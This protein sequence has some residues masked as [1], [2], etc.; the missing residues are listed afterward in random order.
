M[1][2]SILSTRDVV[3]MD[4][5]TNSFVYFYPDLR[6][7]ESVPLPVDMREHRLELPLFESDSPDVLY[8]P[9]PPALFD[10]ISKSFHFIPL[11]VQDLNETLN[12]SA[13]LHL[14]DTM[15]SSKP[16]HVSS[17]RPL[18]ISDAPNL[19]SQRVN[20]ALLSTQEELLL[21]LSNDFA[22]SNYHLSIHTKS[23]GGFQASLLNISSLFIFVDSI[24]SA[25]YFSG[26]LLVGGSG[27]CQNG[28]IKGAMWAVRVS[29]ILKAGKIAFRFKTCMNY[30]DLKSGDG[31]SIQKVK[32]LGSTSHGRDRAITYVIGSTKFVAA[33]KMW[34]S[35]GKW[36]IDILHM[37]E[38]YGATSLREI[39]ISDAS[40]KVLDLKSGLLVEF[41]GD[42][43]IQ[44]PSAAAQPKRSNQQ[45]REV[46]EGICAPQKK[47]LAAKPQESRTMLM[48]E[49]CPTEAPLL[50]RL[51]PHREC[52][53][54][55]SLNFLVHSIDSSESQQLASMN[56]LSLQSFAIKNCFHSL[57]L[58]RTV[59]ISPE[60]STRHLKAF[61][62][63]TESGIALNSFTYFDLNT[64]RTK[65]LVIED[66]EV[67]P[68]SLVVGGKE[69]KYNG[70]VVA[71]IL[72]FPNFP[73][74]LNWIFDLGS[75]ILLVKKLEGRCQVIPNFW[76]L[77]TTR[78]RMDKLLRVAKDR[79]CVAGVS[80][81]KHRLEMSVWL[82][83]K[84]EVLKRE[85]TG[86]C[87]FV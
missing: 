2:L 62:T 68:H 51:A 73:S 71:P 42:Y 22:S 32:P 17:N 74:D 80:S 34:R 56:S 70:E 16:S 64:W 54:A 10:A 6:R 7:Y 65:P 81:M 35:D 84:Q 83:G 19:K 1:Q 61:S 44:K 59:Q 82:D 50:P 47:K 4:G 39:F 21:M 76:G 72:A 38:I 78:V 48:Q 41:L 27:Y 63:I 20:Q 11:E 40:I 15:V 57:K 37:Q 58:A 23:H 13:L 75:D 52:R 55:D 86:L 3:L 30:S 18:D 53:S 67:Q 60:V 77:P 5:L 36:S 33:A 31:D 45:L 43:C 25:C 85:L 9:Q 87:T 49:A 8:I 29:R 24:T 14:N 12:G 28:S 79:N 46:L 69:L 66:I 26:V